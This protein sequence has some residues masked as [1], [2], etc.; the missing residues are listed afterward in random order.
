[1]IKDEGDIKGQSSFLINLNLSGNNCFN[2]NAKEI[3][4]LSNLIDTT[5][6]YTLDLSNIL[7]GNNPDKIE[8]GQENHDYRVKVDKLKEKLDGEREEYEVIIDNKKCLEVDIKEGEYYKKKYRKELEKNDFDE[9]KFSQL[10]NIY[11][12]TTINDYRARFPLFL[13]EKAK[14]IIKGIVNNK[15]D[16]EIDFVNFV[17]SKIIK[18]KTVN[19]EMYKSL[20]NFLLYIMFV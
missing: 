6:L 18:D 2:K 7:Y 3:E 19:M 1:M 11:D 16:Y 5:S 17:K 9:D 15:N 20:E 13:R 8:T 12:D 14:E 10:E 4:L